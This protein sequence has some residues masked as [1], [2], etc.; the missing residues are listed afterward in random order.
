MPHLPGFLATPCSGASPK[1]ARVILGAGLLRRMIRAQFLSLLLVPVILAVLAISAYMVS[2]RYQVTASKDFLYVV[3]TF[4]GD[5]SAYS[6]GFERDTLE[7]M[8][9]HKVGH[10]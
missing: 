1:A 6:V 5:I 2:H 7:R 8:R 3:D 10:K 4:N 9:V